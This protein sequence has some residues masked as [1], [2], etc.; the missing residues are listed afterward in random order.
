[1]SRKLRLLF[2]AGCTI[3]LLRFSECSMSAARIVRDSWNSSFSTPTLRKDALRKSHFFP[4]SRRAVSQ[5][6]QTGK[7]S[8]TPGT[9]PSQHPPSGRTRSAT[10]EREH[11]SA[12]FLFRELQG[13][14]QDAFGAPFQLV[15]DGPM[16]FPNE[17]LRL[18]GRGIHD[19]ESSLEILQQLLAR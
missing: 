14:G 7:K 17:I 16:I 15:A 18:L 13:A 1:M 8:G 6:S 9:R 4:T 11:R 19:H 12:L 3:E 10:L 5:V 2:P